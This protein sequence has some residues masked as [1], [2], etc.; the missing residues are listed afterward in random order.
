MNN[1]EVT[2]IIVQVSA[3]TTEEAFAI[4]RAAVEQKLV[5]CAHILPIRS[6]YEWEGKVV[7]DAEQLILMKTRQDV[8]DQLED[9]I[10]EVHSYDV[11]EIIAIPVLKG[12]P[13]Y[14]QWVDEVITS[15]S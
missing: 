2:Y 10:K 8:Y 15:K 6:C 5:A 12:I 4:T 1:T 9:C 11:P 3:P 14:L 7:E 13:S